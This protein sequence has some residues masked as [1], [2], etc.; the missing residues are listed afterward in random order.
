MALAPAAVLLIDPGGLAPFG[1]LKWMAAPAIV[2]A[3]V[4]GLRNR[5]RVLVAR[6]PALVFAVFLVWTALAA[7]FGVEDLY[8]WIGTPE[9]H[10]GWL[11]W[12]LCALAFVVGQ[13]LDET[14]R[15]RAMVVAAG[16]GGLLGLWATAEAA[17]WQPLD[18]VGAGSRPVGTLG[19]SAYLGAAAVLL[20]PVAFGVALDRSH[21]LTIRRAAA[22]SALAASVALVASGARAAWFGAVVMSLVVL[23]VRRPAGV[24]ARRLALAGAAV[25]V[26]VV[27]LAFA[28]GV[29]DR[30]PE[31]ASDSDG[32][33]RGRLDEWRVAVRVVA[34]HPIL[35]VGPE[36]YRIAFGAS[37]DDDYEQDHGRDPLPDRAH[38]AVLDVAATTGLPGL[39]L[40]VVLIVSVGRLLVRAVRSSPL[41]SA[42]AAAGVM[43]YWTQSLF[44]FP[45]A[46]L[47][48]VVWLLA[49]LVVV[50]AAS[51]GERRMRR[52]PRALPVTAGALAVVA[53]VAG[54]FDVAAD[55]AARSTLA[56]L[57]DDR[58]VGID[59]GRAARLRP[60]AVRY[61]LV[62][63]RVLASD[64]SSTGLAAAIGQLD[65][66]LDFSP[67]DPVARS[68]RA[69][70]RLDRARVTADPVDREMAVG[71]LEALVIDDP[72]NAETL[73][74]LGLARA[75][76]DDHAGAERAWLAAER[77]APASAAASTN[78]AVAYARAGRWDEARAA[79]RRALARDPSESRAQAVLENDG[80]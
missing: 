58:A 5:R 55:R 45:V 27:G 49:G 72:R 60:D 57:A 20:A 19:S 8:A 47:E 51:E 44:L 4:A 67:L 24:S 1:P 59:G 2:L 48:P 18:L 54:A 79:A 16:T 63:A 26:T 31:V 28:T 62:A 37:V 3:G 42:G 7:V 34:D 64:G 76:G 75:L 36:G 21:R 56:D 65:R 32:G 69:R 29:A 17:G 43:A 80:T 13:S 11:T 40:Y 30:L 52:I 6:R 46:E 50:G 39:G 66:A 53:A 35:G 15:R 70:F 33:A 14:A 71:A 12:V 61:Q 23:A 74:R 78:L 22:V 73:L 77:L 68:E 41:W 9:R 10:F 38:S 25:G